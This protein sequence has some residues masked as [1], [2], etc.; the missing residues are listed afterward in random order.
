MKKNWQRQQ[1]QELT[2]WPIKSQR[3]QSGPGMVIEK[4]GG[5]RQ[6]RHQRQVSPRSVVTIS[7]SFFFTRIELSGFKVVV[8]KRSL[9]LVNGAVRFRMKMYGMTVALVLSTVS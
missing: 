6:L 7:F 1:Y 4:A 3:W 8:Y 9:E 5:S 2:R